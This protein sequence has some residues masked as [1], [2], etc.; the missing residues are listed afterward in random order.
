MTDMI[1]GSNQGLDNLSNSVVNSST[2]QAPAQAATP[3]ERVF[4]QSDLNE[5]VGREKHEAVERYKRN[6]EK[7]NVNQSHN[8]EISEDR[9]RSIAMEEA[10]RHSE[11]LLRQQQEKI[12]MQEATRFAHDFG[13]KLTS[14]SDKYPELE[15][16]L[17]AFSFGKYPNAVSLINSLD[18]VPDVTYE[19]MDNPS[20]FMQIEIL[21]AH[22]PDQARKELKKLS[23]SIKDNQEAANTKLPKPPLSQLRPSNTGTDSAQLSIRDYKARYKA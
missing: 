12:E 4:R 14:A 13:S 16:G 11:E 10:R 1:T 21:A 22:D 19:L 17:S 8:H 23:K 20:K 5:I 2:P 18:N 7:D 9:F 15:K 6:L 3:E